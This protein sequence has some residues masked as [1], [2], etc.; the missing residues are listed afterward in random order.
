MSGNHP[1]SGFPYLETNP[2]EASDL[3]AHIFVTH[4]PKSVFGSASTQKPS[5]SKRRLKSGVLGRGNMC[6]V[7]L[8]F[9]SRGRTREIQD[10]AQTTLHG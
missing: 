2:C 7:P 4:V 6:C 1:A 3:G 5:A 9:L 10:P 8:G